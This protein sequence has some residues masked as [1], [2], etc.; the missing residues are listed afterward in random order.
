MLEHRLGELMEYGD[1]WNTVE[2]GDVEYGES[3]L[4][5]SRLWVNTG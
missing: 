2:Y 1:S 3:L 4:I 5:A